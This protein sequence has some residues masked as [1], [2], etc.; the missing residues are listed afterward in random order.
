MKQEENDVPHPNKRLKEHKHIRI[1]NVK[2]DR[3]DELKHNVQEIRSQ[4]WQLKR[5]L[6]A[7]GCKVE[8]IEREVCK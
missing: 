2:D 1:H 6:V 4:L 8:N 3:I 7:I 5:M